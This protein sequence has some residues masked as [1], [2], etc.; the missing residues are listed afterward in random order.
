M[1]SI[2]SRADDPR[3]VDDL[4]NAALCEPED[5]AWDA[6]CALHFRGTKEVFDRATSLCHSECPHERCLGAN[7][8]GPLGVP[9]RTY[10]KASAD[11]LLR[12]LEGE[13]EAIVLQAI[14]VA[15]NHLG[16]ARTILVAPRFASHPDPEV[17]HAVEVLAG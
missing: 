13:A 11:L 9:T 8:L 1:S 16:D 5:P 15:L 4:I 6:V 7:I 2:D 10:P 12:M 3:T 17:R 14:I